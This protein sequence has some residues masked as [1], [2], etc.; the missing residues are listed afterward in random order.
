MFVWS[1]WFIFTLLLFTAYRFHPQICYLNTLWITTSKKRDWRFNLV[2]GAAQEEGVA[3]GVNVLNLG[4]WLQLL[5]GQKR[6]SA[7]EHVT[8]SRNEVSCL[9]RSP[10]DDIEGPTGL[11]G[12]CTISP[13]SHI[14]SLS[15]NGYHSDIEQTS[16]SDGGLPYAWPEGTGIE[17]RLCFHLKEGQ[18]HVLPKNHFQEERKR[19]KWI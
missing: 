12:T 3:L 5:E 10:G 13:S 4:L 17:D 18:T 6:R 2:S 9:L 14:T 7:D 1:C 19:K 15:C 16:K 11:V 8:G